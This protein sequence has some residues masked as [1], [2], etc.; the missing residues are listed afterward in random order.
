MDMSSS[1]NLGLSVGATRQIEMY[2]ARI[3]LKKVVETARY[4][5]T[6]RNALSS[7]TGGS[8]LFNTSTNKL[9][10]YNGTSWVD[11]H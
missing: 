6:E 1:T 5:T 7:P 10:V 3:E 8:L 11:L 9:Q 2:G 4:T